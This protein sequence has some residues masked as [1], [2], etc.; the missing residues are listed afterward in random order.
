MTLT[1]SEYKNK[2][3]NTDSSLSP[4][5]RHLEV[6]GIKTKM[7]KGRRATKFLWGV[8]NKPNGEKLPTTC[9]VPL[10]EL[11]KAHLQKIKVTLSIKPK[12]Y[13]D[14]EISWVFDLV[15]YTIDNCVYRA[16]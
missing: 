10:C 9:W 2:F 11:T 14:E 1:H 16:V 5:K 12:S 6:C 8:R 7:D 3:S 4:F 13:Q 15:D